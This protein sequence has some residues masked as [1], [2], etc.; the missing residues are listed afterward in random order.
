MLFTRHGGLA[1]NQDP[2]LGFPKLKDAL[3]EPS[4]VKGDS[5]DKGRFTLSMGAF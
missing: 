2:S 5:S 4:L 3:G 1:E